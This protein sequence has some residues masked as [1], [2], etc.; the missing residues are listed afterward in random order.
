VVPLH[1][2]SKKIMVENPRKTRKEKRSLNL[3]PYNII[4]IQGKIVSVVR[5]WVE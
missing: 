3:F 5:G 4:A 2:K 1:R